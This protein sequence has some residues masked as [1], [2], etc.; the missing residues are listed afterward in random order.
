LAS[1]AVNAR[2]QVVYD[3]VNQ[4]VHTLAIGLARDLRERVRG[5]VIASEDDEYEAARRVWNARIDRYPVAVVRAI[6]AADIA[7][8]VTFAREHH[9]PLSVR[10]GGHDVAGHG[11]CDGGLVIDC[12]PMKKI[13]VD[14]RRRTARVQS[15][16]VWGELDDLTYSRGL[17][18]TGGQISSTGVA[19]LT[20]GG[21]L[22]WLMRDG[23]LTVD[24]LQSVEIVTA[25]G[26]HTV[27]SEAENADLFWAV[28]GGGGNFGV[29][30]AFEFRLR[31]L[32]EI[33]GGS[34]AHPV[35]RARE[36]LELFRSYVED[37][38]DELTPMAYFF[39]APNIGAIPEAMRGRALA[40]IAVCYTGDHARADTALRPLRSFGPPLVDAIQPM[41]YTRLQK[42]FDAGSL[43]G[44]HNYWRS[45]YLSPLTSAGADVIAAFV[46]RMTSPLSIVLLTP[47]GGA[48]SRVNSE[49]T[50]FGHRDAA[51]VLEILA[52]WDAPD[53]AQPHVEWAD[54]FF[55]AMRPFSTGGS[56]VN[57]LGDEGPERVRAAFTPDAFARLARVKAKYD[58]TNLFRINQNIPPESGA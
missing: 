10:G 51:L 44:F 35:A 47:M 43:P 7:A 2:S 26:D 54:T 22:G 19:G 58:P 23:G 25:D 12:S 27:A 34:V 49:V 52:K 28:R 24:S 9:L 11:T 3:S 13:D 56:Y 30:T 31:P 50:A 18:V 38:P 33:I 1:V 6:D 46:E 17:A 55:E 4:V 41:A 39:T 21:G 20:L 36:V 57:F 15:G 53:A 14:M 37:V 5:R 45:W 42:L 16:V 48:V 8:V 32:G 29:V 40:S